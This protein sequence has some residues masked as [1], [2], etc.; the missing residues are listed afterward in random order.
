MINF[1][2]IKTGLIGEELAVS[3]LKKNG[4]KILEKN[5]RCPMGEVDIVARDHQSLVFVEVK[6]RKSDGFGYP[7][8]AVNTKKQKKISRVALHYL[9]ENNLTD[10]LIRFDVVAVL[11]TSS[12]PEMKLIKDAFPFAES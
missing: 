4:Y 7:E 11:M 2:K 9:Q 5:Y 1:S 6:T 3:F 12:P 10:E 8:E